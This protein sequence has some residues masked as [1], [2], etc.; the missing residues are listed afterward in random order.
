MKKTI[1]IQK[2]IVEALVFCG[3]N[4]IFYSHAGTLCSQSGFPPS[5]IDEYCKL[6]D[7][8]E[9]GFVELDCETWYRL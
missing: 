2:Q 5:G 3:V 6:P 9:F 8:D 7:F 4:S 1:S